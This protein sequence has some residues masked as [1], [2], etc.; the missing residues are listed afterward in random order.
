MRD[1]MR[2][3]VTLEFRHDVP[4]FAVTVDAPTKAR[5]IVIAEEA[6]ACSGWAECELRRIE[7]WPVLPVREVA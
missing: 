1:M 7:V 6:A 3:R 4:S 5:A 2:W